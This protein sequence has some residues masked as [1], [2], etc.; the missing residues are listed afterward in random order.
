MVA[1]LVTVL[2]LLAPVDSASPA[3]AATPPPP[4]TESTSTIQPPAPAKTVAWAKHWKRAA[5]RELRRYN[6]LRAAFRYKPLKLHQGRRVMPARS[7]P[8]SAWRDAGLA[9]KHDHR[10]YHR[11]SEH[12]YQEMTSTRGGGALRWKPLIRYWWPE[13]SESQVYLMC[14][15]IWHES[16]G[17]AYVWNHQGSGAF[18]LFQLLPKPAGVWGP[19]SQARAARLIKYDHGGLGHWAGSRGFSCPGGCGIY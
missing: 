9:W 15:I 7:A 8:Q 4:S 16:S 14:H 5:A 2:L 19:M 18:G 3:A 12:L 6:R 13:W 11:K 10:T 17:S 1:V